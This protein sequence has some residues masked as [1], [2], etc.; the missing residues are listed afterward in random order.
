MSY[1]INITSTWSY[2]VYT[3]SYNVILIL[4]FCCPS[5]WP[6]GRS[7][8]RDANLRPTAS[9]LTSQQIST[10]APEGNFIQFSYCREH[11][12]TLTSTSLWRWLVTVAM[13]SCNF[14]PPLLSCGRRKRRSQ[15][16]WPDQITSLQTS[17]ADSSSANERQIPQNLERLSQWVISHTVKTN[18][19]HQHPIY[20]NL[21]F[22]RLQ[23]PEMKNLLFATS[24]LVHSRF[25]LVNL[26]PPWYDATCWWAL[27][28]AACQAASFRFEANQIICKTKLE[29]ER[30]NVKHNKALCAVSIHVIEFLNRESSVF[31][32]IMIII[33]IIVIAITCNYYGKSNKYIRIGIVILA[34]FWRVNRDVIT[35]LKESL[36]FVAWKNAKSFQRLTPTLLPIREDSS[37]RV[38]ATGTNKFL[39]AR[40][41]DA[42]FWL[43]IGRSDSGSLYC[44]NIKDAWLPTSNIFHLQVLVA[45]SLDTKNCTPYSLKFLH[46]TGDPDIFGLKTINLLN[47]PST[48]PKSSIWEDLSMR[49][50]RTPTISPDVSSS[51]G[52]VEEAR[53]V[54][55]CQQLGRQ[56]KV[57]ISFKAQ[58]IPICQWF[59]SFL[60]FQK[61][62]F[63]LVFLAI[64]QPDRH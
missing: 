3:I 32:E 19:R 21:S 26:S 37:L 39:S 16:K 34:D 36:W 12:N 4:L 56:P 2:I 6:V 59:C 17:S 31:F 9:P 14:F 60:N 8:R 7:K 49:W 1:H 33:I 20:I 51:L 63:L 44:T 55:F 52:T 24:L 41:F 50:T 42:L 35:C 22:V 29:N 64:N 18:H 47:S 13:C 46:S 5:L 40:F 27:T 23:K 54:A 15:C 61:S 43:K 28:P 10:R 38:V 11:G 62:N 57:Q 48:K 30:I 45:S 25:C 58:S 53:V